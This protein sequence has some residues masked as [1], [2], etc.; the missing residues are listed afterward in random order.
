M[1]THAKI[2]TGPEKLPCDQQ[3]EVP[4]GVRLAEVPPPRHHWNDV[5]VCPDCGRAWL[6]LGKPDESQESP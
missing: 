1:T 5:I 4:E 3:C 6:V 2:I